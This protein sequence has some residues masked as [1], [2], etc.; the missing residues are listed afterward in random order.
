MLNILK[1]ME[2]IAFESL[3]TI[4]QTLI[5]KREKIITLMIINYSFLQ[6]F[7]HI[8]HQPPYQS[9][10]VRIQATAIK[11]KGHTPLECSKKMYQI[12]F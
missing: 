4:P 8:S 10:H 7:F 1:M 2:A 12:I 3:S 11:E 6:I 5:I 9:I